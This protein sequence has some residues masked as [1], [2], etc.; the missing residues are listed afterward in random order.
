L[1]ACS[2]YAPHLARYIA[3]AHCRLSLPTHDDVKKNGTV[4]CGCDNLNPVAPVPASPIDDKQKEISRNSDWKYLETELLSLHNVTEVIS[5][6]YSSFNTKFL[7]SEWLKDI[8]HP[9][10]IA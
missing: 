1:L 2:L 3:Y 10:S 5:N 7:K 9:P 4:D 6:R 8:F